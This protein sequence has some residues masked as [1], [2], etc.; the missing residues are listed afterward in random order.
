MIADGLLFVAELST[1]TLHALDATTGEKKWQFT[2]GG[3][4]DSPPT[5]L[6]GAVLFG[7]ADGWIYCLR[8]SDGELAWR[9][10]AAK[11]DRRTMSFEQ[12]ESLWPVHGSVLVQDN[13]VNAVS[14]RSLF[15]D[16]GMTLWR[17]DP[18]SGYVLSE[19]PLT[20]VE[21]ETGKKHE[22]FISWLNMPVALPDILSTDNELVYMRSQAFDLT[23]RR[24]PLQT[25]PKSGDADRGAPEA[26]QAK[27]HRHIFSPTGFLD[28]DYWHRSYWMYGTMFVSGWQGYYRAGKE[29]PSGKILVS[30]E[31]NIY[32]FGRKPEYWKWTVPIEHQLFSTEKFPSAAAK[33]AEPKP[34][35]TLNV[36][37]LP[38]NKRFPLAGKPLT[39]ATW[40]KPQRTEGVIAA[41]GGGNIGFVLGLERGPVFF[42]MRTGKKVSTVKSKV[43]VSRQWT[44]VA[45][46]L[47]KQKQLQVYLNGELSGT[48]SGADFLS[49]DP[50]E[51]LELGIDDE[52]PVNPK[53]PTNGYTG[54]VEDFRI[55]SRELSAAE[56]KQAA[57]STP[58]S[59]P[60]DLSLAWS[61]AAG[62]G[63]DSSGNQRHGQI[64]GA[65]FVKGR[66]GKA[67]KFVGGFPKNAGPLDHH[68]AYHWTLD[69]PIMTRAL[70][71]SDDNL[72]VAGPEDFVDESTAFRRLTEDDVRQKLEKTDGRLGRQVG[73]V[74]VDRFRE[75]RC[76]SRR[77]A[78]GKSPGLQRHGG[79]Q[80]SI[81][82]RRHGRR[83]PLFEIIRGRNWDTRFL[84]G[85]SV[86]SLGS[87]SRKDAIHHD[88]R[89]RN[90]ERQQC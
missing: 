36:V 67:L 27:E 18:A 2:A 44:H 61:F 66:G 45:V 63:E 42:S 46:V 19:T 76:E 58:V 12:L 57:Q 56:I 48:A 4:I 20:D 77:T 65:E 41:Y 69:M 79:R 54:L 87:S 13:A 37:R 72:F 29:A 21:A 11:A 7:S 43:F 16:G 38:Q 90:Y 49:K 84:P 73:R 22:E 71:L 51:S 85:E 33:P 24:L 39:L 14:G 59:D 81:V 74:I 28:D 40:I 1:H 17:L 78:T 80:R 34:Q 75:D 82:S 3:R 55:W 5:W 64:E 25:P 30:D 31:R 52:T 53:L 50:I 32:G 47:T 35:E 10:L 60:S 70:M 9:F 83:G 15:L 89:Q 8:S 68:V 23:G 62:N 88:E 6:H 26:I 86:R